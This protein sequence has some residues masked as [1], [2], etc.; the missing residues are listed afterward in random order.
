MHM[1]HRELNIVP[2][3]RRQLHQSEAL[4]H[5][6]SRLGRLGAWALELSDSSVIWSDEISAI[7]EVSP[8]YVPN[9]KS[10]LDF[11]PLEYREKVR[12]AFADC[13]RDG[14]PFDLELEIVTARGKRVW[15]RSIGE[16]E[17]DADGVIRRVIGAFQDVSGPRKT[18]DLNRQLA[19]R[20]TRTLESITDAFFTF[21]SDW[22]FTYVNPSGEELLQRSG[23]DLLGKVLW[24][25]FPESRGTTFEREY[26]RAVESRQQA[27]FEEFY[28]PLN[29][30]IA[31]HVYPSEHGQVLY[32]R[33]V[34]AQREA[35]KELLE[36]EQRFR[37]LTDAMPHIVWMSTP[38][39]SNIYTNQQWVEYTGLTVEESHGE[40][41]MNTFHPDDL[42]RIWHTWEKTS[43][44]EEN[45]ETECRLRGADGGYRWWLVR[46]LPVVDADGVV[47]QWIG[48]CTNI[49]D[50]KQA[51]DRVAEQAALIDEVHDAIV[52]RDL[53]NRLVSWSRGAERM[54]GWTAAEAV[55][56]PLGQILRTDFGGVVGAFEEVLKNGEWSGELERTTRSGEVLTVDS[57][58]TLLRDQEG[59]PRGILTLDA[60]VSTRKRAELQRNESDERYRLLFDR[61][62]H[63]TWV[64]DVQTLSFL[65]VNEAAIL[66]YGYSRDEFLNMTIKDIRPPE[67]VP[68]FLRLVA[69]RPESQRPEIFGVFK[70]LQKDGALIE[71]EI[72]SCEINYSG[73]VAGLVIAVD[74]TERRRIEQQ[75]LRAQRMES[76]GTLAGGIAHD[77]N[78]ILMPVMMG[79]ALLKR[80]NPSKEGLRAIQNMERSASRGKDLVQ[81]VLSFA[82]GVEGS[83]V[84]VHIAD[85]VHE[86]G[87]IVK[88]TFPKNIELHADVA[89]DLWVD[90]DPT[91]LNQVLL[92][93]CVNARDAMPN[94]GRLVI[95]AR[96]EMVDRQYASMHRDAVA[97]PHV[98][99]E[100]ADEGVGIAPHIV[101]RIFEPF[102][103][104]KD[105]GNGTGLGLSTVAA[106]VRSH[107][108]VAN[109][110]SEVGRGSAFR[111]HL[112]ARSASEKCDVGSASVNDSPRGNGELIMVVDDESS[113]LNITRQTLETFGYRIITAENGA[114]ALASFSEH[115]SEIKAVITDMM[116]PIMDGRALITALR[117]IDPDVRILASSG[118]LRT[119]PPSPVDD[120]QIS[121]FLQKPFSAETLLTTLRSILG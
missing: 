60:D 92:N 7:H 115:R 82:R 93:L 3:K 61:N 2:D 86:V 32:A 119:V 114:L 97:G 29:K 22:R 27:E 56:R 8:D 74:V 49:D 113:I 91:Q 1:T 54:Y 48:T 62:P 72:A 120:S 17:R 50:L 5:I 14:E 13:I 20:L 101:D 57:R 90:G 116:M 11:Y 121:H 39:G 64:Y 83:R 106:I 59:R 105:V 9:L 53:Q 68:E 26:R 94:G 15:V 19:E 40:G 99:I 44:S 6:A 34:T 81:Q 73:R 42:Q 28:P 47:A 58:S 10:S 45:F 41:W 12:K 24:D 31:V 95:S 76:I 70:H 25:E 111:V 52:V 109:V 51:V 36:S 80:D 84:P 23:A 104:T 37:T 69:I 71:A 63:P 33:D 65:A 4:L 77:L 38:A 78:N 89:H 96:H 112:P 102:F 79:T 117:Q 107:N 87:S 43:A 35:R 55:G 88:S 67:E 16:A 118:L 46:G 21:D 18:A 85:I 75:F 108:G 110:Y 30:W 100:V 98:L 103:T 66:R